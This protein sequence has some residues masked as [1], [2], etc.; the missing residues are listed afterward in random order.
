M[1]VIYPHNRM[2]NDVVFEGRNKSYG[3]Y[4]LRHMYSRNMVLAIFFSIGI[5][6][7]VVN[8]PEVIRLLK[9]YLPVAPVEIDTTQVFLTP[10]PT[11]VYV[12][13]P[14]AQKPQRQNPDP[15]ENINV[16]PTIVPENS[17]GIEAEPTTNIDSQSIES[18]SENGEGNN[19][20]IVGGQEEEGSRSVTEGDRENTSET[21]LFVE[22]MPE[23]NNG[24]PGLLQ[25][26]QKNLKYP[27]VAR[28][29]GI[30]GKVIIQFIVTAEGKI[31]DAKVIR[32]I[33]GGCDQEAMRVVM[34]MPDWKPGRH[35]GH[36]VPVRFTLPIS[37]ELK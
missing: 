34:S 28:Q 29:N 23:F 17:E 1:K 26:L 36:A 16:T 22:Q 15:K 12:S 30:S 5:F 3:A 13:S 32:G 24:Y 18:G 37:F 11:E 4:F 6:F 20:A 8:V 10:P 9:G 31:K 25:Y 21:F 35:N 33:G 27:V 19:V 14:E 7:L 2:F